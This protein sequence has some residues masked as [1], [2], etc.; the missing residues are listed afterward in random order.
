MIPVSLLHSCC[1]WPEEGGKDF[2]APRYFDISPYFDISGLFRYDPLFSREPTDFGKNIYFE[3]GV[4]SNQSRFRKIRGAESC[5]LRPFT[6]AT[7]VDIPEL[8][9]YHS[10][11]H[12]FKAVEIIRDCRL[13]TLNSVALHRNSLGDFN[14]GHRSTDFAS[15]VR[16]Q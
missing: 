7:F 3:K 13:V 4:L 8:L 15:C 14:A 16:S 2:S 12:C 10:L 5:V 9:R 1:L 11:G 6:A